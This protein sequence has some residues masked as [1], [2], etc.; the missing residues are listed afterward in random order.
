MEGYYTIGYNSNEILKL[1]IQIDTCTHKQ[2][3]WLV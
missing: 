1:T 3:K 2:L